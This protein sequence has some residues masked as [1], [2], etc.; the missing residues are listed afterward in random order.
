MELVR[1]PKCRQLYQS[2]RLHM[3]VFF[4]LNSFAVRISLILRVYFIVIY[5]FDTTFKL[6][7]QIQ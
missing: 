4:N 1:P 6:R 3:P 2:T 5:V 7:A